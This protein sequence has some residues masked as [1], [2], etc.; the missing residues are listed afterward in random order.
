MNLGIDFHDTISYAPDFFRW[1]MKSW[2]HKVYVVSGTPASQKLDIV[3]QM[4][5]IDITKDLYEDILLGYEYEEH[6]MG[7]DHFDR[8]KIHKLDILKNA[9]I[10]IYYDD[11]PFYVD[12]L[13][14]HGIVVFQT[15]LSTKYLDEWS[16]KDPLF[17]C[18]LQRKQFKYLDQ[19]DKEHP[20]KID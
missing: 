10:K 4:N 12:Y 9:G 11:N 3:R 7:V 8:M 16:E 19:L 15:I 2:E 1:L 5:E 13:K 6:E 18:N 17:T 14:D 20:S